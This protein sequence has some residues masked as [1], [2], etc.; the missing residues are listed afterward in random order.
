MSISPKQRRHPRHPPSRRQDRRHPNVLDVIQRRRRRRV[1][2]FVRIVARMSFNVTNGALP[3]SDERDPFLCNSCGYCKS[4]KFDN[5]FT[6]AQVNSVEPIENDEDRT[7]TIQQIQQ[8]MNKSDQISRQLNNQKPIIECLLNKFHAEDSSSLLIAISATPVVPP[9][10][11]NNGTSTDTPPPPP[12]P[13]PPPQTQTQPQPTVIAGGMN[14]LIQ[15]IVT[16]YNVEC[17]QIYDELGKSME[18]ILAARRKLHLYDQR[19]SSSSFSIKEKKTQG[20]WS[21]SSRSRQCYGCLLANA[22]H[23][24]LLFRV[25]VCCSSSTI[26]RVGC[27]EHVVDRSS[28]LHASLVVSLRSS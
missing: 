23:S 19:R 8:L 20:K 22:S 24:V 14:R 18:K 21:S 17:R 13:P 4:C 3:N 1:Q 7:K 5:L 9:S 27:D 28:S 2:V 15:Q 6:C 11:T 12:P 25:L 26:S 10:Q 16:K